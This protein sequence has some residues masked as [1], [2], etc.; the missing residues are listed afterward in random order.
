MKVEQNTLKNNTGCNVLLIHVDQHRFDCLGAYG[1]PDIKTPNIDKLAEEGQ[2]FHNAF[3]SLPVC[4]PSRYSLLCGLHVHQHLGWTN[5]STLPYGIPTFP[6]VLRDA[7]YSTAAV[8]KMHFTPTYLDVGFERMSLCEQNGPGRYDDDYHRWLKKNGLC[9]KN[10]LIDQVNEYRHDAPQSYWDSYGVQISNLDEKHHSTTWIGDQACHELSQWENGG[11]L[12]MVGFVKPHHPFDPPRQWF[13]MYNPEDLSLL[14][15]WTEE[16]L[17]RD[18]DHYQGHF[19]NKDLNEKKVKKIM[20]A[21][22]AS[23]SQIDFQVGRIVDELK[24]N[25]LYKDSLIIFTSDHGDY[26]GYHHM[27]LKGNHMYDPVMKIPL[28][29]KPPATRCDLASTEVMTSNIDIA[30]TICDIAGVTWENESLAQSLVGEQD[31]RRHVIAAS[32]KREYMIRDQKRKFI[33]NADPKKSLFFNLEDDPYELKSLI[34]APEW[35]EEI[36]SYKSL[37]INELLFSNPA[38]TYLNEYEKIINQKNVPSREDDHRDLLRDYFQ[39]F[40]E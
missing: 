39:S 13:D 9:D 20:A 33:W 7:G 25:K 16:C 23:I 18:L 40:F 24:K 32:H 15:G 29:I 10:D 28:I 36:A 3:C 22:Y 31:N 5:H 11:N 1:N 34:T 21:Y 38:P 12:L 30:P 19:P 8:G 6:K 2:C 37:L 35:Q 14:S 17:P 27:V 4:T 26:M